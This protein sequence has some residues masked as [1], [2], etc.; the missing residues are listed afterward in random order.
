MLIYI[1]TWSLAAVAMIVAIFLIVRAIQADF[2]PWH[3]IRKKLILASVLVCSP[4]FVLA[5]SYLPSQV[6]GLL[7][8]VMLVLAVF[9][10]VFVVPR[11]WNRI[12]QRSH[13]DNITR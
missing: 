10:F 6:A 9:N 4:G 3:R 13:V 5:F 11:Q 8:V 12:K 1:S 7:S 2:T